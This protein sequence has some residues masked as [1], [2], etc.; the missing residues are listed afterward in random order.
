MTY[1]PAEMRTIIGRC[2]C[3]L[4]LLMAQ[5]CPAQRSTLD[6]LRTVMA[7]AT[8]DTLRARAASDVAQAFL[9]IGRM[10][11][12][13]HYA[14]LGRG[15]ITASSGDAAAVARL[16]MRLSKLL[17]I[18]YTN[19][20]RYDS[21]LVEFQRMERHAER[22]GRV[23]DVAA[24]LTY[25]GFQLREMGDDTNALAV[26]RRA[27]DV[28]RPSP[29]GADMANACNGMGLIHAN[30]FS[31]D[32]ALYWYQRAAE[33][34]GALG[35]RQHLR[36]TY[37]NMGECL[38]TAGRWEQ[39]DSVWMLASRD[40][41]GPMD[42]MAYV[43]Y[44]GARARSLLRQGMAG[45]AIDVLDSA[46]GL[47]AEMDDMEGA[48]HLLHIRSMAQAHRGDWNA[49][50]TD[51]QASLEAYAADMDHDKVRSTEAVRQQAEREREQLLA[52]AAI[53]K[54]RIQKWGAVVIGALAA[55]LALSGYRSARMKSRAAEALARKNEEI[56]R[57]QAQLIE[58]EKQREAEQVRT[59]IARDIHDDIGATLTKIALLSGVAMQRSQDPEE[60]GRTFSRISEH[61]RNVSRAL[62]DVVWAVD[63]Q[64][65]T[66]QGML[67][68]VRD[69]SQR[70]LGDN[71]IRFELVLHADSPQG[72]IAP[73][74]K[75]DLHLVL[76]ECF[77][78]ILKYAHAKLVTVRLELHTQDFELRVDDDG[79]GFDP[80]QV[81]DRGNGLRN[82]P[83][84][85][86]QHG[87]KL[88][89]TSAPGKGTALHARG[90]LA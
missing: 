37:L 81:P 6:S 55:L 49:A 22:A 38:N 58:S 67:E 82:M 83:A 39:A 21:G 41:V 70:L 5:W 52:Q 12:T 77:N 88:V 34:Y 50:M 62:S 65:D 45:D 59:R 24:A 31:T 80:A 16:A 76:N 30:M 89:V 27:I 29:E 42:P 54:Q 14:V 18:A 61:T 4:L 40:M 85:I 32:S 79:V 57:A 74:L 87:G 75:R 9:S 2:C 51:M 15:L 68:H 90:P 56:Q 43:H 11:S 60:A 66:H 33:L 71:G 17:G 44:A 1:N 23:N 72:I 36:N 46:I 13:I 8:V 10:D 20:A 3:A 47:A 35:N 86:A 63:P 84:R 53:E 28:L 64:R 78:N 73:A 7:G 69:L 48:H 25:Q 19:Q 26:T